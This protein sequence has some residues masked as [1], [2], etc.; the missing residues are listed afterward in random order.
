MISELGGKAPMVVFEDADIEQVVNGA[1][2]ASFV[3]SGQVFKRYSMAF[4]VSFLFS[5]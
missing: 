4:F 5:V 2:F 3:A 1:A